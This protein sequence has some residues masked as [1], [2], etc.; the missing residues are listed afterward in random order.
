[1]L[2]WGTNPINVGVGGNA[3]GGAKAG[4]V[5]VTVAQTQYPLAYLAPGNQSTALEASSIGG[6]GGNGG[7]NIVVI[8][9]ELI[10]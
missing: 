7:M 6:G 9:G 8:A 1:M 10:K 2:A 5:S 4:I 3:G